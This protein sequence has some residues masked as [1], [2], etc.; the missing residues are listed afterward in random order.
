MLGCHYSWGM[1]ATE[2]NT[3]SNATKT[4]S[5]TRFG[6]AFGATCVIFRVGCIL[7]LITVPRDKAIASFNSLVH[8]IDAAPILRESIMPGEV[9]LGIV[10]TLPLPGLQAR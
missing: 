1:P 3:M 8:G 5:P 10:S 6:F 9:L 2:R 4:I 7:T